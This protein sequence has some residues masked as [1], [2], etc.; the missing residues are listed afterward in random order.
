[1]IMSRWL[2][3]I[4]E[5]R[6][7]TLSQAG[8]RGGVLNAPKTTR[9]WGC[10]STTKLNRFKVFPRP[11]VYKLRQS[12]F[13][14]TEIMRPDMTHRNKLR[15]MDDTSNNTA[16][17]APASTKPPK[18]LQQ[19]HLTPGH[20]K[21]AQQWILVIVYILYCIF[22]D[23]YA[24]TEPWNWLAG[25]RQPRFKIS[26]YSNSFATKLAFKSSER[27]N[28]GTCHMSMHYLY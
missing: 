17:I 1:M 15:N 8:F 19:L 20:D 12:S 5:K 14:T 25:F 9:Q 16:V 22:N 13:S 7:E 21:E 26:L 24:Y 18:C 23:Q 3:P 10:S 6:Q 2:Q 27:R 11:G 4:Q 28:L